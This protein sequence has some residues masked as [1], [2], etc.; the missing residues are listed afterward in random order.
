MTGSPKLEEAIRI[1]DEILGVQLDEAGGAFY[2]DTV[3]EKRFLPDA[4]ACELCEEAADLGWIEDEATS[5]GCFGDEDG[6]PLHP[7]CGCDLEY[8]ERRYRVYESGRR[9]M[10]SERIHHRSHASAK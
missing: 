10:E 8:R 9:V 4:T 1:A 5:E 7:N 6:P 2:Y 3:N